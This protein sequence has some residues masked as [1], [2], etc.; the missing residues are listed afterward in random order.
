MIPL[1]TALL[2]MCTPVDGDSGTCDQ[3][4]RYRI[5]TID[6]AE[7][8]GACDYERD[9]AQRA[10]AFALDFMREP[11]TVSHNGKRDKYGRLLVTIRRGPDDLGEALIA[12]GLARRW[13]GARRSWCQ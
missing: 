11:V 1:A 2:L 7:I 9:L 6:T 10:K 13:E 4:G 3:I 5:E 8:H 12:A